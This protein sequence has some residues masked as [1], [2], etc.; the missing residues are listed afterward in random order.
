MEKGQ[1]ADARTPLAHSR[2]T[3]DGA[4]VG[5]S[6]RRGIALAAFSTL[7]TIFGSFVVAASP[8][9][10]AAAAPTTQDW[11][12]YL[13]DAERSAASGESILNT[14]N[15]PGLAV[16][17]KYL[18][19]SAIL[20]PP[21][22]VNGIVYFGSSDGYE[23]AVNA[24]NGALVWKQNLG[25][26]NDPNCP[27][28]G[29]PLGVT[30]GATVQNGV[31][32]VGGGATNW[33]ALNAATGA[34]L[35]TVPTGDNSVTGAHYNW[36]SPLLYNGYAYIG[37]AS[38]CDN[39][40]VQGELIQVSLG[41]AGLPA[42]GTITNV[43]KFVPDGQVGGG[44]WTSPTVDP[45][46]NTIFVSTGTINLYT[47]QLSQAIVSLDA[48]TLAIKSHWQLPF[49]VE[50]YNSDWGTTPTLT[51]DTKGDQLLSVANKNGILYTFN[52]NN[53]AAGPIWQYQIARGGA[54]PQCG[55]GPISSG[56]FVSNL[57]I[58]GYTGPV[59][60][61]ASP[62]TLINGT[63]Y[64]GVVRAFNP[65]DGTVL[66][67]HTDAGPILGSLAYDNGLLAF[68]Q[69]NIFEVLDATTGRSVYDYCT[70][71]YIFSAAAIADGEIFVGNSDDNMY[72]FNLQ[73]PAT[74]PADPNCPAGYTCQDVG[75]PPVAGSETVN[76]T[77]VTVKASG[78]GER[79]KSDQGRIITK[80]V[81]GDFQVS[82]TD[83][84]QT[85][86]GYT[87]GDAPQLGIIIRQ[88]P[89]PGSPYY[90]ALQDPTYP[91]EHENVAN[92]IVFYRR[93][94]NAPTF[95][96]TQDYPA[97]FPRKIVV[98]R[99]G[100]TFQA[101]TSTDGTHFWLLSGTQQAVVMP[102]T[103]MAGMWI[104]AGNTTA[105]T[106]ASFQ[107]LA[108]GANTTTY[109]CAPQASGC[110]AHPCPASWTCGD[111]DDANPAGDQTLANGTWSMYGSGTGISSGVPGSPLYGNLDQF[112]YV[113]QSVNNDQTLTA[114][115]MGW[116]GTKP[117]NAQ[118]GIMM[119]AGLAP[120]APY[121]AFLMSSTGGATV[122]WRSNSNLVDQGADVKLPA[123]AAPVYLRIIR[124]TDTRFNPPVVDYSAATST[125]GT[126][127]T[128]VQ[129]STAVID[130]GGGA[131]GPTLMGLVGD[132]IAIRT[133]IQSTWSNLAIAPTTAAPPGVCPSGFTCEDVGAAH[134]A[135]NQTFVNQTFTMQASG[136]M[137]D[138]YDQF[139]YIWQPLSGDGTV[140]ARVVSM[141]GGDDW[142]KAGVMLRAGA[143]DPQA[144][145][146]GVFL[147]PGHGVAVQ[148]R[149]TEGASTN[150]LTYGTANSEQAPLYLMA[151]RYTDTAHAGTVYYTAYVSSDDHTWTQIP[152]STIAL[153]LPPDGSG[154]LAAGMVD[155]GHVA[156]TLATA[157]LDNYSLLG[158]APAPA[159]I[160]P[161]QWNCD[162]I[163]GPLP[164]GSQ[165]LTNGTW[166]ITAGGGDYWG[167][168]NSFHFIYQPLPADGTVTAH[169]VAQAG[170]LEWAKG[171]VMLR[172]AST[173]P[174]PSAP[175]YG[176]FATPSHGVVVQWRPSEGASTSQL[177]LP[178]MSMPVY[179]MVDRWTDSGANPPVT[180]Y[181]ALTSP[182]GNTWTAV[183]GSTM[184]LA[185]LGGALDAGVSSDSWN[186]GNAATWTMDTVAVASTELQP[187]GVCARP[188]ECED[189]GGA[190]PPGTQTLSG[191]TWTLQAGGGDIWGTA[192]QFH[193]VGQPLTADGTV[194]A[195]V[196]SQSA[197]NAWAKAGVM[198]RAA[199]GDPDA[200]APYYAILMTPGHGTVVQWRPAEGAGT[201]SLAVPGSNPYLE[202]VRWTDTSGTSPVTYFTAYTSPDGTT[203][204]AA[205]GS[206]MAL[207]ITGGLIAGLAA[208]SHDT[209]QLGT[210]TFNALSVT[211]TEVQPAGICLASWTC[212]DI[213]NV[214][215][216]GSQNPS[217]GS[218]T[219]N[220]GGGDIFG[221]ADS[222]RYIWQALPGDGTSSL[223]DV[224]LA[225]TNPW[226]KAGVM[227]RASSDAGAAYYG[228]FMT[229]GH[230]IV[231]QYR[232][233]QGGAT[234]QVAAGAGAAPVYLSVTRSGTTFSAATSTNGTTWTTV[235]GSTVTIAA[236]GGSLLSGMAATSHDVTQLTTAV[237]NSLSIP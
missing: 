111:V 63:G 34:V 18:T 130:M 76:G 4:G 198:L 79:H 140:S 99:R 94:W 184:Q 235:P 103:A 155:D 210:D 199:A 220:A 10:A 110:T 201:S 107:N 206:T 92:L 89:L 16:S 109:T 31:V 159:G 11:P 27:N 202:V 222:F 61:Y 194:S 74:P 37:I 56:A 158:S 70:N 127:W 86:G 233:A 200:G 217:N 170:G 81:T 126:N 23:Y 87:G 129:G 65:A 139:R 223:R 152:Y 113:Y 173:E 100:D 116:G 193:L 236:L 183:P 133:T 177:Q 105:T 191:G 28:L 102:T 205:P 147:T 75:G 77:T 32:Y 14:G 190:T 88:S 225:N 57:T 157:T 228:I 149:S 218:W 229:P 38:N 78:L 80:P 216:A 208:T 161:A 47:Q 144:P 20:S 90:A 19:G 43:A 33:Y 98:Q 1:A 214:T 196:V 29:M 227:D 185:A 123:L 60:F 172:P 122:Q 178:A 35:Y 224:S 192:D 6:H 117:A 136:D 181:Q 138:V 84:N 118:A 49:Q 39:P 125:D 176:I 48:G 58:G 46:T 9:P 82:V 132:A 68:G 114:E 64:S 211:A 188:V 50:T 42:A 15:A 212:A 106:T 24:S 93:Q 186:Q 97:A 21:A 151:A 189:I 143:T 51:T 101:L 213:G 55:D 162:D 163:G 167:T 204:T 5:R 108:I 120:G 203:W 115:Y 2:P 62:S 13:H 3:A 150:Q 232:T 146:Y 54:C 182:D 72:A 59:L 44:V 112:H 119:R 7:A 195:D 71:S 153:M 164:V 180:Y 91:N 160:C 219:V 96:L 30:S 145:Y 221:T 69:G 209:T 168:S 66:W 53:L 179:L 137:W 36:A 83:T 40:L 121:Y 237:F 25:T 142:Q 26:T 104:S 171:G 166:S 230:G 175:Y 67:T 187:Q 128:T 22:V 165:T 234:T 45:A 215:P 17:W 169:V 174:D 141:T 131:A 197:T 226:T 12:T 231:V 73:P 124:Y 41:G 8:A 95:E 135:G 134:V 154:N 207:S 52:R 156:G 148:W 85:G